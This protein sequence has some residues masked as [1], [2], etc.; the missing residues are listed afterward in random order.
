MGWKAIINM[1]AGSDAH[2][3]DLST[4]ERAQQNIISRRPESITKMTLGSKLNE[5]RIL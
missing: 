1:V 4:S 5:C 2:F 3:L